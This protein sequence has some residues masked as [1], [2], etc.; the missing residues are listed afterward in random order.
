[1]PLVHR[2]EKQDV[3]ASA[4]HPVSQFI[5]TSKANLV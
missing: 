1:M 2:H 5:N 4:R 3:V